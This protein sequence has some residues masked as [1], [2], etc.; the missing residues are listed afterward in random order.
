[1]GSRLQARRCAI[2][3]ALCGHV[4][5]CEFG[6]TPKFPAG[7]APCTRDVERG[8]RLISSSAASS[9][10]RLTP[11]PAAT[12]AG[13]I[14]PSISALSVLRC[15]RGPRG[16][17]RIPPERF[18]GRGTARRLGAGGQRRRLLL[19]Q[20][21]SPPSVQSTRM[22]SPGPKRP[23]SRASESRSSSSFWMTRR[24]GP[25]AEHRVVALLA[26]PVLGGIRDF[27][28]D[29]P[30][31]ELLATSMQLQVDDGADVVLASAW[32]TTCCRC[33]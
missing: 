8:T 19:G 30:W 33:G 10:R 32:K 17:K 28:A 12:H 4:L 20:D 9:A 31:D 16:H 14:R 11:Q 27:H 25:G 13:S 1:M 3:I 21:D 7:A 29:R 2:A 23:A 6:G 26:Q 24:S 18:E 15:L 5:K 22:V